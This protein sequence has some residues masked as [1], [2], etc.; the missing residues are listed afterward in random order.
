LL[1]RVERGPLRG[2]HV[3][4]THEPA[5]RGPRQPGIARL[6]QGPRLRAADPGDSLVQMFGHME[7]IEDDLGLGF[8]EVSLSRLDRGLPLSTAIASMPTRCAGVSVAQNLSRLSCFRSSARES[9]RPRARSAT[10]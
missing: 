9:T 3:R 7:F 6:L 4:G 1:H 8:I 2:C 10:R 5:V